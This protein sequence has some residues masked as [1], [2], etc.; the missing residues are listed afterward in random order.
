MPYIY[1]M[2][3]YKN[4]IIVAFLLLCSFSIAMANEEEDDGGLGEI[5]GDLIAFIIGNM[6]GECLGDK[7][8]GSILLPII[9]IFV[10]F[11][12][13]IYAIMSC[14]DIYEDYHHY[15]NERYNRRA[16]MFGAGVGWGAAKTYFAR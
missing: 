7:E 10:A 8:C 6:V 16:A 9:I 15:S 11:V 5:L 1:T 3:T 4:V 13:I 12:M 14:C 2:K